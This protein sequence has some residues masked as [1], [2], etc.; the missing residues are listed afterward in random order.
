MPA[1][2]SDQWNRGIFLALKNLMHLIGAV[3]F[4]YGIFFDFAF[5]Y[6]PKD[7][8]AFNH[9]VGFGGKLRYLTVIG[10]VQKTI[11]SIFYFSSKFIHF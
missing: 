6:P 8:V 11:F 1:T 9:V 4:W 3:H 5:V 2:K 7:H 10:A